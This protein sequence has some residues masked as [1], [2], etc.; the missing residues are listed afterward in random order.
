MERINQ[1]IDDIYQRL[2]KLAVELAI[3]SLN[4][5][6]GLI[7]TI[8][9]EERQ[10]KVYKEK[11]KLAELQRKLEKLQNDQTRADKTL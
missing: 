6:K 2:N 8:E 7:S 5:S 11:Q 10:N 9:V 4:A 3:I 1:N